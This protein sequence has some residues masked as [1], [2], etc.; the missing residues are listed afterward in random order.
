MRNHIKASDRETFLWKI[1]EIICEISQITFVVVY[2]FVIG[3]L[4]SYL[5]DYFINIFQ[6]NSAEAYGFWSTNF[7]FHDSVS[8]KTGMY[9]LFLICTFFTLSMCLLDLVG[10][11]IIHCTNAVFI[12]IFWI[13]SKIL[14]FHF[15]KILK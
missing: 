12:F 5:G 8:M 3:S 13:L 7:S 10:R 2:I 4:V 9:W 1:F 14:N 15:L 6:I 11:P